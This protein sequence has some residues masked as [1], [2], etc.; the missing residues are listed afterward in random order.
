MYSKANWG[1]RGHPAHQQ[2]STKN[3]KQFNSREE[4]EKDGDR[5]FSRG[6]ESDEAR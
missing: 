2:M 4:K 1:G 6:R 3:K 5:L